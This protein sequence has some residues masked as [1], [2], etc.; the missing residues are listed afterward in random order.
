MTKV[1]KRKRKSPGNDS[2]FLIFNENKE[3]AFIICLGT[4]ATRTESISKRVFLPSC[5][6]EKSFDMSS[7]SAHCVDLSRSFSPTTNINK[8]TA[9]GPR[10]ISDLQCTLSIIDRSTTVD[11]WR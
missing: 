11:R 2:C 5:W 1:R 10:P 3:A 9:H 6:P 7:S 4:V 8:P